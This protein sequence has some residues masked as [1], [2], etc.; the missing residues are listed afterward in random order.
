MRF[1]FIYKHLQHPEYDDYVQPVSLKER[2]AHVAEAKRRLKTGF[3]WIVDPMDNRLKH[4]LG[5][6]PNAELVIDPKGRIVRKRSWSD[7]AQLRKDL[8]EFVGAVKNPTTRADLNYR[9]IPVK[10]AA[11]RGVVKRIDRRG[12]KLRAVHAVANQESTKHPFYVKLRAE[13]DRNAFYRGKGKLYL[14]FHLD[15]IYKVHWNHL[16]KPLRIEIRSTDGTTVTP[17]KAVA[18]QVKSESDID[19]REFLVDVNGRRG[20][21][22]EVTVWYYACNDDAGWC[23]AVKQQWRVQLKADPDSGSAS[24]GRSSRPGV[25]RP[26][27]KRSGS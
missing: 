16:T 5:N 11:A 22:F 21:S 3:Q 4:A 19:P 2:L 12:M 14:G 18:K 24:R 13:A 7:P 15:P 9:R 26:T 27:G 6:R 23:K 25:R 1:Y 20:S 10:P 17:A 8:T